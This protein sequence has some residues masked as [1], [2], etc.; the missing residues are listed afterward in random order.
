MGVPVVTL[1]GNRH[2]GRVGASLLSNVGLADLVARDPHNYIELAVQLAG[3]LPRL[4][5]LHADLRHRMTRSPL[6]DGKKFARTV[7]AAY[8]RMWRTWLQT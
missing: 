6:L 8:R 2:A 4:R 7:E 3:D 1:S 5:Q